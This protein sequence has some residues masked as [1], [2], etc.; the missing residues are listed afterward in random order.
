MFWEWTSALHKHGTRSHWSKISLPGK[1]CQLG[2]KKPLLVNSTKWRY[3]RKRA[4]RST[5]SNPTIEKRQ[6]HL[7]AEIWAC[8][9]RT[10]GNPRSPRKIKKILPQTCWVNEPHRGRR[11]KCLIF[12]LFFYGYCPNSCFRDWAMPIR[13]RQPQA[14]MFRT[15]TNCWLAEGIKFWNPG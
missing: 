1:T 12:P 15:P 13:P 2:I 10:R 6:G 5:W 3:L 14:V 4:E 9:R 7:G 11:A 8:R